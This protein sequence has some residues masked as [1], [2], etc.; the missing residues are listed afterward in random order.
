M[1]EWYHVPLLI[2]SAWIALVV[3]TVLLLT[4]VETATRIFDFMLNRPH[5]W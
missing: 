4:A 3:L 5:K 1:I 2:V